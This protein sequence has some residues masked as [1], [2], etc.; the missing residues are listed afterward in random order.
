MTVDVGLDPQAE[1][2]FVRLPYYKPTLF[3]LF[4]L[5]SLERSQHVQLRL[6]EQGVTFHFLERKVSTEI[7]WGSSSQEIVS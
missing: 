1:A 4:T 3:P 6:E 7:I 2:V 5:C